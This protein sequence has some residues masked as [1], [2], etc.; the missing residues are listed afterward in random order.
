MCHVPDH[1]SPTP[2]SIAVHY[3]SG[4]VNTSIRMCRQLGGRWFSR[5]L[6]TGPCHPLQRWAVGARA[7]V[8]SVSMLMDQGPCVLPSMFNQTGGSPTN[9]RFICVN[10]RAVPGALFVGLRYYY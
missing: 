4:H 9:L 10:Q 1:I 7:C 5:N 2:I 8:T 3:V 6:T